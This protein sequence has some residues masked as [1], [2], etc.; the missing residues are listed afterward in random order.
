MTA[1]KVITQPTDTVPPVTAPRQAPMT[2][3]TSPFVIR[4]KALEAQLGAEAERTGKEKSLRRHAIEAQLADLAHVEGMR[5]SGANPRAPMGE[6]QRRAIVEASLENPELY[7][8][9][10]DESKE[11]RVD[12][13][14]QLGYVKL[15]HEQKGKQLGKSALYGIP[16]ERRGEL[17]AVKRMRTSSQLR[18]YKSEMEETTERVLEEINRTYGRDFKPRDHFVDEG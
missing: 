3:S 18:S 13:V 5:H 14:Q 8:R 4:A 10:I 2:P 1:P 12:Y 9:F 7:V 11:G 6:L 15:T 17:E 16:R